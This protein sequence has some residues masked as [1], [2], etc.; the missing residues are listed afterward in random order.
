MSNFYFP[1]FYWVFLLNFSNKSLKRIFLWNFIS[2]FFDWMLLSAHFGELLYWILTE[3]MNVTLILMA[4]VSINEN[5]VLCYLCFNIGNPIQTMP[6]SCEQI[7]RTFIT[8]TYLRFR[9]VLFLFLATKLLI[10]KN[11]PKMHWNRL[12]NDGWGDGE[13]SSGRTEQCELDK[14]VQVYCPPH[15]NGPEI[16]SVSAGG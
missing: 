3:I 16:G 8:E 15:L 4:I 6:T 10:R 14:S 1:P 7:A 2:K 12:K 11:W 5:G 9:Y 13:M